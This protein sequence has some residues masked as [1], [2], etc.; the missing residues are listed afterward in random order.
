MPQQNYDE[1][2]RAVKILR[3]ARKF[4]PLSKVSELTGLPLSMISRYSTEYTL[5]S[6]GNAKEI[7]NALLSKQVISNIVATAIKIYNGF[8][9]ISGVTWNPDALLLISEYA[10]KRFNGEFDKILTPET[11]GI[12]L[13]T[14]IS[15]ASGV[16]M[17]IARKQ[18]PLITEPIIDGIHFSGPA[19]YTVFYVPKRELPKGKR[20]LI[21]DDFSV[22]GHTLNALIELI[23]KAGAEPKSMLVIVG[24]GKDWKLLPDS[25]A[26]IEISG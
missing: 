13:A 16:P 25:E 26:L 17:V 19:S 23:R 15:I 8:Y 2:L 20:I 22:R 9:D 18:R 3:S 14:S 10:K 11:G 12:S 1:R 24:I 21:V 4:L 5:P 7:L 6:E